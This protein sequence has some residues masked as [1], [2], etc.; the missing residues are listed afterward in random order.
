MDSEVI[1]A[2]LLIFLVLLLSVWLLAEYVLNSIGLYKIAVKKQI[3]NPWLAWV[4]VVKGWIVGKIAER[5]DEK[6][7]M[8]R[9]WSTVLVSLMIAS[10]VGLVLILV[11]SVLFIYFVVSQYQ[12]AEPPMGPF[13]GSLIFFIIIAVLISLVSTASVGCQVICMYK[14]IESCTTENTLKYWLLYIAV[15]IVG[16]LS[17]IKCGNI[18]ESEQ[19]AYENGD[20]TEYEQTAYENGAMAEYE[21]SSY[22][23]EP[24]E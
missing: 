22:E 18:A 7:G 13:F 10:M 15:P 4:P 1:V 6:E 19:T 20:M 5:H 11:F 24:E 14:V 16:G 3:A 9:K 17:L 23:N 2:L 8:K 12:Y 21:Q